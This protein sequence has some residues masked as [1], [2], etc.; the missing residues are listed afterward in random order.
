[1]VLEGRFIPEGTVVGI[2][3]YAQ[4]VDPTNFW[5]TPLEFRPE[6]WLEGGLGPDTITRHSAFMAFQFGELFRS[7]SARTPDLIVFHPTTGAFGCL[8]K[9]LAMRQLTV[10]LA[11]LLL[12]YKITFAPDFDPNAFVKGWFNYRTNVLSYPLRVRTEPR[13]NSML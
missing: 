10:V 7:F 12:A 8:G 11:Q 9:P 3:I 13:T 4:H 5:P 2:P 6:R 1:M